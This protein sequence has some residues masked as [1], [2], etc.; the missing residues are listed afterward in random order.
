MD[1]GGGLMVLGMA[2]ALGVSPPIFGR[3][4]WQAIVLMPRSPPSIQARNRLAPSSFKRFRIGE[5]GEFRKSYLCG[6]NVE[7]KLLPVIV[8]LFECLNLMS[9]RQIT[10]YRVVQVKVVAYIGLCPR[11]HAFSQPFETHL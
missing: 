3:S 9:Q 10:D 8:G 5:R 11:P 7:L 2:L 4:T 6:D 1:P